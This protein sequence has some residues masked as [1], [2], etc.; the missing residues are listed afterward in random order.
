MNIISSKL[1][2]NLGWKPVN[3]ERPIPAPKYCKFN[4]NFQACQEKI[5]PVKNAHLQKLHGFTEIKVF[6]CPISYQN[7]HK[8]LAICHPTYKGSI[9]A[10]THI[11]CS[12]KCGGGFKIYQ[13]F[14][15]YPPCDSKY[16]LIMIRDGKSGDQK[17]AELCNTQICKE[18]FTERGHDYFGTKA[19]S[20]SGKKC[21]KYK[22]YEN[23]CQSVINFSH[24]GCFID[25]DGN[26]EYCDVK[27]C[28][29][30]E[31]RP[32]PEDK[33]VTLPTSVQPI[34]TCH[35]PF[36]FAGKVYHSCS[37]FPKLSKNHLYCGT[38]PQVSSPNDLKI[39]PASNLGK[40]SNFINTKV[41]TKPCDNGKFIYQR[42]CFYPPCQEDLIYEMHKDSCNDF[43]CNNCLGD[44]KKDKFCIQP[45]KLYTTDNLVCE[46]DC[47]A[48][49]KKCRVKG[50]QMDC[51]LRV[52]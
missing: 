6:V 2:V 30:N 28:G 39:C 14:C 49:S 25:K 9:S 11:G 10:W 4:K 44:G 15:R 43:S 17:P 41:C 36:D 46:S 34:I 24:P 7:Y 31:I 26:F 13:R 35:F 8:N 5:L 33:A 19:T 27:S 45:G 42:Y 48:D 3:N 22:K 51:K 32:I 47:D 23:I 12:K 18:C 38:Q 1:E 37:Q 40:V 52:R 20:F 21:V 29:S 16:K 50:K